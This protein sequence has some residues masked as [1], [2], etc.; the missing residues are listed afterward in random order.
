[1][2]DDSIMQ[3]YPSVH[4]SA[5]DLSEDFIKHSQQIIDSTPAWNSDGKTI[6]TAVMNGM[7]LKFLDNTFDVAF[8]S[9]A[10]FAYPDP[11][12]CAKELLRTLKP[13]GVA[14]LTTWKR[15]GWVPLLHEVEA[16]VRPGQELSKFPFLE[17]WQVPG[18]L[19]QTLTDGGLQDVVESD[20]LAYAWFDN[21]EKAAKSLS[22]TLKLL[23][24]SEWEE[25]EKERMSDG[26]KQVMAS[27]SKYVMR[28]EGGKVGFEM[29]AWT[30]V[31]KK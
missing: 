21:E 28:G 18:K 3:Q 10:I 19:E 30:G 15:V 20:V 7:D 5:V 24:G 12:K 14:A 11:I 4:I 2:K 6:D 27:E 31:G 13:G 26:F 22:D 29:V 25:A 9:L 1:M 16:L 23:V 17:P 8:T